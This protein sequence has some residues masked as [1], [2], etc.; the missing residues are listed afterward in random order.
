MCGATEPEGKEQSTLLE[1]DSAQAEIRGTTLNSFNIVDIRIV[2]L[3]FYGR[4]GLDATEIIKIDP[5]DLL[6]GEG[7][8]V[9][10]FAVLVESPIVLIPVERRLLF[11]GRIFTSESRRDRK[12]VDVGV[13]IVEQDRIARQILPQDGMAGPCVIEGGERFRLVRL[14]QLGP[15]R[16][17]A[18]ISQNI[19]ILPERRVT[20]ELKADSGGGRE[21]RTGVEDLFVGDLGRRPHRNI[22]IGDARLGTGW[23][24]RRGRALSRGGLR[25]FGKELQCR[26]ISGGPLEMEGRVCPRTDLGRG[27][28]LPDRLRWSPILF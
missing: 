13:K 3:R 2:D 22:E 15:G 10:K 19:F 12:T 8:G 16:L 5:L 18:Q 25:R 21:K 9:D 28:A 26:L 17:P 6:V 11:L 23:R 14:R 27:D 20:G 1:R 24:G 7:D 4:S